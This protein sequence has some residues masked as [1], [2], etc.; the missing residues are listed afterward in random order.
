MLREIQEM[1]YIVTASDSRYFKF[2]LGFCHS[3]Y[4]LYQ[5]NQDLQLFIIDA[6]LQEWEKIYIEKNFPNSLFIDLAVWDWNATFSIKFKNT[7]SLGYSY[8]PWLPELIAAT[9]KKPLQ[10]K[11]VIVW[12]DADTWLQT[13]KSLFTWISVAQE[14]YVGIVAE[15]YMTK[16]FQGEMQPSAIWGQKLYTTYYPNSGLLATLP[17]LNAG[18]FSAAVGN[19]FWEHFKSAL[20][21]AWLKESTFQFGMDQIACNYA[22][23]ANQCPFVPLPMTYNW[24]V[25]YCVPAIDQTTRLLHS[26]QP[27]YDVLHVIHLL[28]NSKW[29]RHCILTIEKN[30]LGQFS[31]AE[32]EEVLFLDWFA[33]QQV[34]VKDL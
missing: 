13:P 3:F 32:K 12:I 25:P 15:I 26:S 23:Y 21:F 22:I 1:N 9:L 14:N 28:D 4:R 16:L 30:L 18:I 20:L 7:E 6:G 11:D 19:T 10:K 2:L 24:L 27:P 33:V 5:S 8:R 34:G 17:I 31:K 29:Q